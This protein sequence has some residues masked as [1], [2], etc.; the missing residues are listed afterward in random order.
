SILRVVLDRLRQDVEPIALGRGFAGDRRRTGLALL[1]HRAGR[2]RGVV[3]AHWA[4]LARVQ[5]TITLGER[6]RMGK[7]A[8][9]RSRPAEEAVPYGLDV[10][11]HHAQPWLLP[12]QVRHLLDHAGARIL[13]RQD[14]RVD[15]ADVERIERLAERREALPFRLREKRRYRLV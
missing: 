14:G 6:L 7:R 3:V 10:L 4:D 2:A 11:A 1:R 9:D 8:L 15:C 12:Q 5:I 13:D